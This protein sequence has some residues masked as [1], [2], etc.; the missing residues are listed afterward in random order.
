MLPCPLHETCAYDVVTLHRLWTLMLQNF[1]L[2]KIRYINICIN[3]KCKTTFSLA[4]KM[5]DHLLSNLDCVMHV[6]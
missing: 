5:N 2:I 4:F 3:I 6:M 1:T